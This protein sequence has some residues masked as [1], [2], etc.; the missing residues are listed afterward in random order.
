MAVTLQDLENARLIAGELR[1]SAGDWV[2]SR[3]QHGPYFRARTPPTNTL[4]NL[5][6]AARRAWGTAVSDWKNTLTPSQRQG[7]IDYAAAR[8]LHSS[9]AARKRPTGQNEYVR[10][11]A[12]RRRTVLGPIHNAP[13]VYTLPNF[14]MPT[15]SVTLSALGTTVTA[16]IDTTDPW[17][18][19]SAA[20]LLGFASPRLRPSINFH[21]SPLKLRFAFVGGGTNPQ[22][23]T[24]A[25]IPAFS[26][27]HVVIRWRLI[28]A[29]GRVSAERWARNF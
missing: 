25:G 7:W 28:A 29:D 5:R 14:T 9:E 1:G 26:P 8:E 3:N 19:Q 21:K 18:S 24:E 16:T 20:V 10:T 6:N 23:Y 22:S 12:L 2:A 27:I 4:T 13:S 15:H 17:W 11:N